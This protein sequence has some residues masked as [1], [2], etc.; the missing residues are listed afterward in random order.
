MAT[1]GLFTFTNPNGTTI[2]TLMHALTG[3]I[4]DAERPGFGPT[5]A[6]SLRAALTNLNTINI[7]T[8]QSVCDAYTSICE[9]QSGIPRGVMKI[10]VGIPA[11]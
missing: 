6:T 7:E 1:T 8:V 5:T 3:M 11:K 2:M 10:T 9:I 4:A